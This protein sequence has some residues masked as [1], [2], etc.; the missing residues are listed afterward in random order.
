MDT[1]ERYNE[2]AGFIR[3]KIGDFKPDA[4]LVM[5]SGLGFIADLCEDAAAVSYGDVPHM[6][7]ST[8]PGHKGRFVFGRIAGK[9]VAVMQGRVHSYEGLTFGEVA[10]PIRMAAM[11]GCK[12]MVVTNASG[13]VNLDYRPGDIMLITDHIKLC[14][15]SPLTGRNMDEFGVRFPDM[16]T[17]Y[18]PELRETARRAANGLGRALKEGVYM[19]F[20]GPQ[21]ETPAEIRAARLLGAD[22]VGM[23]TVPEVIAARHAGMGILGFSLVCNMAAGILDQPLTEREVLDAAENA[24]EPFSEL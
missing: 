3:G 16:T 5:G 18:T 1:Y 11:L 7:A 23:S 6:P 19:F 24:K 22:V 4:L 13:A 15:P 21:Y 20:A 10:A 12:T 14:A 17:A 9:R 8:A 2:A